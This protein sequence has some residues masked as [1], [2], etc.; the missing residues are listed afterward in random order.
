MD[1]DTSIF[2][3][4]FHLI[5]SLNNNLFEIIFTSLRVSLTAVLLSCFISIP[6]AAL[7]SIKDFIGKKTLM[8]VI[9]ALMGLPPV[10]VG[11]FIYLL[12]SYQG[13]LSAYNLLYTE[14]AMII[15]QFVI[16]TPIIIALSKQTMDIIYAE[17]KDFI[18]SL[19]LSAIK[20]II[21]MI[22]DTRHLLIVTGLAGLGRALAEVG[23]VMIVGGNIAHQTR[24]MTTSIALETSRGDQSRALALGLILI[25]LSVLI[26]LIGDKFR[27]NNLL[28]K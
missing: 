24:M 12:L 2:V 4:A 28:T 22:Y 14:S 18:A 8:I 11:L 17:Y 23:A 13:P 19:R 16:V 26:S 1:N 20:A 3:E 27:N 25:F 6:L 7:I 15:A 9:N 10:V 5:T 21:L